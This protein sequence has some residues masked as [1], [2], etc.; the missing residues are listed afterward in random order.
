LPAIAA[1]SSWN[2]S[3]WASL[4][5]GAC[6]EEDGVGPEKKGSV[7]GRERPLKRPLEGRP[8][9]CESMASTSLPAA[10]EKVTRLEGG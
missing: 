5:C 6:R 9:K 2:S 1:N 3:S 7:V 4:V 10:E 8:N